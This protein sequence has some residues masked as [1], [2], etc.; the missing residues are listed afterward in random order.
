IEIAKSEI[1]KYFTILNNTEVIDSKIIK[2]RKA[3]F[4]SDSNSVKQ[5]RKLIHNFNNF[6]I[7]GDWTNTGLPGTIESSVK[8]G[9]MISELILSQSPK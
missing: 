3:T 5:R 6:F 4:I 2:E 8:S 1:K 9:K 7:V